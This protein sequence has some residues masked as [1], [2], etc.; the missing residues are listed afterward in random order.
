MGRPPA[1]GDGPQGQILGNTPMGAWLTALVLDSQVRS[2]VEIGTWKGLGSTIL[3]HE[4]ASSRSE[5]PEVLS[6]ESNSD[7]YRIARKNIP[8]DGV[9]R[10][11]FG[12]I[13]D[14]SEL[15]TVDLSADEKLWFE[16]DV[17]AISSAPIVLGELPREISLLLLDGGEF[18]SYAE[19][20]KL[21]DRLTRWLVLDDIFLRKNRRVHE[22]L[23]AKPD[24]KL[25]TVG[26]DRHGWAVWM[27]GA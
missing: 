16:S 10:I 1:R 4:A 3:L 24:W 25:V 11:V 27:K 23:V 22:E 2:V 12:S 26:H 18:S 17:S 6:L 5:K 8:D 15:D 19:F 21:E 20:S 14:Q 7:F 13:V 9:V